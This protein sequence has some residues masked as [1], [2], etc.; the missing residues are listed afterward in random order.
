MTES[1]TPSSKQAPERRDWRRTSVFAS[2]RLRAALGLGVVLSVGVV[3]THAFWT[4]SAT[5]VGATFS[6]GT[7]D[8]KVNNLD[9]NVPFTS[10]SFASMV[11]GNS[12]SG[13]LTVKN[14]GTAPLKYTA[15][16]TA[17]NA[18]GKNLAAGLVVKVTGDAT[19]SGTSP[20]TTCAAAA[21]GGTGA[22]L[23]G[24]LVATGRLLAPGASE[25]LCVQVTLPA[26]APSALQGA[27]T[28]ATLTFFGTSDLS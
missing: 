25:T 3:G 26:A 12:T 8:L 4:D 27:T 2:A 28:T 15:T 7:I 5:V 22:S 13:V 6:T 20:A 10:I 17:T 16:S 18:D 11:P 19:T 14:A 24:S 9:N 21:L 23:T 1:G